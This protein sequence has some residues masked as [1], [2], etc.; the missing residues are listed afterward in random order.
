MLYKNQAKVKLR[1]IPSNLSNGKLFGRN[2]RK[3]V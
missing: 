1:F 2:Y 3:I